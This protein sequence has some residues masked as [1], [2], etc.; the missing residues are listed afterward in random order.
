MLN[1]VRPQ[2][3]QYIV[4]IMAAPMAGDTISS[5]LRS[6]RALLFCMH[7]CRNQRPRMWTHILCQKPQTICWLQSVG[8]WVQAGSTVCRVLT[9]LLRTVNS[10][11]LQRM[12]TEASAS[13]T[14]TAA[15]S[16]TAFFPPEIR[17]RYDFPTTKLIFRAQVSIYRW[18]CKS[19]RIH[20]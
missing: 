2:E 7:N 3:I 10:D 1:T 20:I 14:Q 6:Y 19:C 17:N 18:G 11:F 13:G 8:E 5:S 4:P 15:C 9:R 16:S 12:Q